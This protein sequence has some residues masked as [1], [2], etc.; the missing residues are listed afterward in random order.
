MK[1]QTSAT[2]KTPVKDR[3]I[4]DF[5]GKTIYVGIDIHQKDYSSDSLAENCLSAAGYH[6]KYSFNLNCNWSC[7]RTNSLSR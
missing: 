1:Q 3:M 4:N 2:S 6:S 7:N 5:T